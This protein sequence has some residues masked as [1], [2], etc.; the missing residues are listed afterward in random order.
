MYQSSF[1]Y[2]LKRY[3]KEKIKMLF[4][5]VNFSTQR[6]IDLVEVVDLDLLKIEKKFNYMKGAHRML[7]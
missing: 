6:M 4:G 2:Q 5:R 7:R 3:G 1:T